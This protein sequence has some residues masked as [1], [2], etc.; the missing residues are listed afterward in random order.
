[1]V[2]SLLD[3][4]Q[5]ADRCCHHGMS[6]LRVQTDVAIIAW[7]A[8]DTNRCCYHYMVSSRYT[9]TLLSLHDIAGNVPPALPGLSSAAHYC[10]FVLIPMLLCKR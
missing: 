7:S 3:S 8:Q 9:Q 4:A 10:S 6:Q 2:L 1:M 5:D